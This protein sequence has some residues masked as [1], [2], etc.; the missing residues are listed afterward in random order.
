MGVI[1]GIGS[2][3]STNRPVGG[4]NSKWGPPSTVGVLASLSG[5]Y[6]TNS[7]AFDSNWMINSMTVSCPK[8]SVASF[9]VDNAAKTITFLTSNLAFT[10]VVG[11]IISSGTFS[12]TISVVADSGGVNTIV[13][14][15]TSSG[16]PPSGSTETYLIRTSSC[17]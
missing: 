10:P 7:V 17:V 12:G 6:A 15:T 16:T 4:G 5:V 9:A 11:M 8:Q 13:T 2:T 1:Q 3:K 14:Y